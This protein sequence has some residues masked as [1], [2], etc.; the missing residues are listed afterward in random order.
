MSTDTS[1]INKGSDPVQKRVYIGGLHPT[2]NEQQI[3]D[4]FNK[5]GTVNDVTIAKN[6]SNECRGFAHMTIETTPKKWETCLSVYNGAKWKGLELKLEEAKMDWQERKR[7]RDEKILEQEEKKKKRLERWNDSEGF[8]S[9]DMSLVTDNNMGSRKGWKRGRYGRAIA[10]MRLKK[11][12]GTKFVFDPSHYKNNLTKLYNIGVRM[13]PVNKLITSIESDTSSDEDDWP[14][15]SLHRS[16]QD[17]TMD[18]SGDEDE[19]IINNSANRDD[20]KRKAAMERMMEEQQA[21]KELISQSLAEQQQNRKNHTTFTDDEDLKVDE[22]FETD[23]EDAP[24]AADGKQ[25]MFDDDD[26]S[27]DEEDLFKINPVLEGEEGRKRLELQ[28]TFKGDERFKLGEDFIEAEETKKNKKMTGDDITQELNAEKGQALDVLRAM[29]GQDKVDTKPTVNKTQTWTNAARFDPDAED[30]S[31]YLIDREQKALDDERHTDD[32]KEADNEEEED[33]DEDFFDQKSR[34]EAPMPVVSTDKHFEVNANLKPLFGDVEEAP[35]T[36]FGGNDN[37]GASSSNALFGQ[38]E[39]DTT[40]SLTSFKPRK[41]ESRLGLGVM[42]FFHLDNP[43]LMK[44]SC[45]AYDADG[46]FQ[47]KPDEKDAYE[48]KW[49]TQRPI[50]KEIL[51]KR[52]K[53]AV[54][55]QKK[56]A[57]RDLK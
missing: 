1:D 23:T 42:F 8:H 49:R 34:S 33:D 7:I 14:S 47:N 57:T 22:A 9:K 3:K 29:F 32:E 41:A 4:R 10:V 54:K 38:R 36:L 20:Q 19:E 5:F 24:K 53:N 44:K 11:E 50:I 43:A 31:K 28:K 16:Q 51:K 56:R 26:E 30:A 6:T 35:F 52:Q 45:Y 27:S 13:K 18:Q 48:S 37:T 55:N 12:D 2:T 46:V 40:S 17:D 39:Q 21:R 15:I 25:W